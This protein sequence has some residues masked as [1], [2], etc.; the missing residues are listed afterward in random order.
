MAWEEALSGAQTAPF[1]GLEIPSLSHSFHSGLTRRLLQITPLRAILENH[2]E[3]A[4]DP[5]L[6]NISRYKHTSPASAV[7][8]IHKCLDE[9]Q[10]LI[11]IYNIFM[12][13]SSRVTFL[14]LFQ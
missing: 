8:V 13:Y 5:E 4:A 14:P 9:I 2:S 6:S 7:E 3:T 11:A 1:P 10:G 12:A